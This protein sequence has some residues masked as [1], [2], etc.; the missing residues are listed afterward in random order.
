MFDRDALQK[1]LDY[2]TLA[3]AFYLQALDQLSR[4]NLEQPSLLPNWTRKHVAVHTMHNAEG[5]MRLLNWA[6]TGEETPMYPS[7]AARDQAIEDDVAHLENGDV[8]TMS[9]EVAEELADDLGTLTDEQWQARVVSGRG[10][11][12]PASDIPWLR[13]RECFIHA[14]DLGIGMTA[15]DF[16]A[17]VTNRLLTEV[18]TTWGERDETVNYLLHITDTGEERHVVFGEPTDQVEITG[19]AAEILQHL[20]GRGWPVSG[21]DDSTKGGAGDSTPRSLPAPPPWL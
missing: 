8:I 12:I 7:R 5:F 20:T 19:Q 15:L 14:L 18:L 13:A 4:A 16:P 17:E 1:D 9:H 11:E 2:R 10:V 21:R 6:R 3:E